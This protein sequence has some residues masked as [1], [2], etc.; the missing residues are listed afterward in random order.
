MPRGSGLTV[1]AFWSYDRNAWHSPRD[2]WHLINIGTETMIN[3]RF[4]RFDSVMAHGNRGKVERLGRGYTGDESVPIFA[5]ICR[6][7]AG[8]LD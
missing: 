8:V 1:R 5:T 6:L 4:R 3:E 2:V 7:A